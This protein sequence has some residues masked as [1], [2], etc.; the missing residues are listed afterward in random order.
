MGETTAMN[1]CEWEYIGEGY[2][3]AEAS[4]LCANEG[5]RSTE[6]RGKPEKDETWEYWYG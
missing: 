1:N 3:P 5:D 4:E 6:E 2:D